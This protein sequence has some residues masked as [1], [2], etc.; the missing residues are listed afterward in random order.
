M[1]ARQQRKRVRARYAYTFAARAANA[2]KAH[3]ARK[4]ARAARR[5]QPATQTR[6][7]NEPGAKRCA[8]AWR[9][10]SAAKTRAQWRAGCQR[11]RGEKEARKKRA[12]PQRDKA[13]RVAQ[14]APA[15]QRAAGVSKPW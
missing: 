10:S 5:A 13:L 4:D 1:R 9:S 14:K 12:A 6:S 15:P 7:G 2:R 8:Q 3:Y 11:K